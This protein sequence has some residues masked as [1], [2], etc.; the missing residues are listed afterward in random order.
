L[1][2]DCGWARVRIPAFVDGELEAADAESLREHLAGCE[3]CAAFERREREMVAR[4]K[5]VAGSESAPAPLAEKIRA[6]LAAEPVPEPDDAAP[7]A[8]EPQAPRPLPRRRNRVWGVALAAAAV[9][10]VL[11]LLPWG[12]PAQGLVTAMAAEHH[13]HLAGA[14]YGKLSLVSSKD[15]T[16]EEYLTRELGV[17]I[18]L[19]SASV[20]TKRGACLCESGG[21]RMGIVGCFCR[22]R[23]KAV[24]IFVFK[25]AGV[26]LGGLDVLKRDGRE[27][28]CGSSGRCRAVIWKRGKVCYALVGDLEAG[29]IR[30]MARRSA[31]A[32]EAGP[33]A[34]EKTGE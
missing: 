34:P 27:F 17:K 23:G 7:P 8:A 32:L 9:L 1:T 15:A 28:L 3:G 10:L 22:K 13:K 20:P 14:D 6:S 5:V 31:A 12:S 18:Q 19:P 33:G 16:I 21:R 11:F 24:T 30:E 2:V 29:D 4:L 25:A 26:D